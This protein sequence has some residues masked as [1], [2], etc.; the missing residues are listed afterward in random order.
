MT[1]AAVGGEGEQAVQKFADPGRG[2]GSRGQKRMS[3]M[4]VAFPG[5][6][7][8]PPSLPNNPVDSQVRVFDSCEAHGQIT[9]PGLMRCSV[10][11]QCCQADL[12][13]SFGTPLLPEPFALVPD[14][15]PPV[16]RHVGACNPPVCAE[17]ITPS[18][19][20]TWVYRIA[21]GESWAGP[22][23]IARCWR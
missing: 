15:T 20:I 16:L 23:M 21:V 18:G 22:G 2:R 5:K 9:C 17:A 10:L 7:A 6:L 3:G 19:I 14:T 12:V 1:S 11:K 13:A 8:F 4:R